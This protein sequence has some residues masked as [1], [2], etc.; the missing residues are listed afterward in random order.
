MK[1]NSIETLAVSKKELLETAIVVN[2]LVSRLADEYPKET[3][4][5]LYETVLKIAKAK[6][7]QMTPEQIDK[8]LDRISHE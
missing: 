3:P 1:N 6:T 4:V 7:M 8:E 2:I 5:S